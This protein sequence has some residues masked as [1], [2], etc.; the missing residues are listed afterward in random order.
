LIMR[1]ADREVLLD[2]Q[3]RAAVHVED[4]RSR[5]RALAI[6]AHAIS[7]VS[8]FQSHAYHDAQSILPMPAVRPHSSF[9]RSHEGMAVTKCM[10]ADCNCG[11]PLPLMTAPTAASRPSG[12]YVLLQLGVSGWQVRPFARTVRS[13]V[14]AASGDHG[15]TRPQRLLPAHIGACGLVEATTLPSGFLRATRARI[16]RFDA[17]WIRQKRRTRGYV[18][19]RFSVLSSTCT[20]AL[21]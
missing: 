4:H 7:V 11:S 16:V 3:A 13:A 2:C 10:E 19:R 8:R 5:R 9:K 20:S 1:H 17:K 15:D 21:R 6:A 18:D 12:K 14:D